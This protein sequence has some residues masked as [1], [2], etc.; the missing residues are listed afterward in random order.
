MR[1]CAKRELNRPVEWMKAKFIQHAILE[2][3][4][5]LSLENCPGVFSIICYQSTKPAASP[6]TWGTSSVCWIVVD[7]RSGQTNVNQTKLI[8]RGVDSA[9]NGVEFHWPTF[10]FPRKSLAFYND[11]FYHIDHFHKYK[12]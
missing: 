2:R 1:M 9:M 12:S 11:Q 8:C 3:S 5:T 10:H 4:L 7:D 6:K